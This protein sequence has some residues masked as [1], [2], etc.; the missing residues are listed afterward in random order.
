MSTRPSRTISSKVFGNGAGGMRA[1]TFIVLLAMLLLAIVA[2]SVLTIKIMKGE[3]TLLEETIRDSQAQTMALLSNRVE[4][5][6]L[7]A[8]R[9]PFLAL[10]NIP[11]AVVDMQR[12]ATIRTDFPEVEQILFLRDDLSVQ[13]SLPPPQ[14]ERDQRLNTFLAQ[15]VQLEGIAARQDSYILH[16]FVENLEDQASLIAVQRVS[17]IDKAS[18]WILIR[19]DMDVLEQRRIAPLLAEFSAKLGGEVKLKDPDAP[20]DDDALNWPVGKILPGWLLVFSATEQ[21]AAQ[22]LQ[23]EKDVMLGVISAVILAMMM[24]TFAVWRELRRE[25][26][27]VDL[28]NRFVANVSHELKTPLSLIR[29]YAETLYLRRV[30]DEDRLHQYHRV[31]LHEA[32]RLSQMINTVLDFSRLSQGIT[33]YR[34]TETDLHRTVEDVLA[35][36]RWRVEDAGLRLEE[37]LEQ[38]VG[39]VAH[40]RNGITQ[41]LIN[42]MDN[43]VKYAAAGGVV[44]VSLR[45]AANGVELA[46]SDH[47]PG[48]AAEDRERVRRPF[49]RAADADPATGSG[50]GLA[51]VEQIAATHHA[52]LQLES[53]ST[54]RGLAAVVCF[55]LMKEQS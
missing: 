7:A 34:L 4:Q 9:P 17:E 44:I 2:I 21:A 24:A 22:R 50:L 11:A 10:K 3:R 25:H 47:G 33:L 41:I 49:Q 32:E 40:D 26:A 36:Y 12:F 15:R 1:R 23:R 39:P 45:A 16:T 5:A 6:L 43:A 53:A 29:M 52:T 51:L 31:L 14:D 18:G 55:P 46:V 30:T 38:D 54:G 35:S 8:L 42:L 37:H 27:L 19:F 28:R 20:W 13:G 48:I